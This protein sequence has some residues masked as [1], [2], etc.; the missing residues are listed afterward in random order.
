MISLRIFSQ[1]FNHLLMLITWNFRN[2]KFSCVSGFSLIV[3]ITRFASYPFQTFV[4]LNP[5]QVEVRLLY[6]RGFAPFFVL[7]R[8]IRVT[9]W[10]LE[11][12]A[13]RQPF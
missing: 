6:S 9:P 13:Y 8:L 11:G 4:G 1:N 3:W 5:H 7:S 12:G 2:T 10:V